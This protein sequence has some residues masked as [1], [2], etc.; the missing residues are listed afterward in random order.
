M[1]E[2]VQGTAVLR[3][4]LAI[5][6]HKKSSGKPCSFQ[7]LSV[8]LKIFFIFYFSII[9]SP[10]IRTI[11]FNG[12]YAARLFK[13]YFPNVDPE[14]TRIILPSTS[15]AHAVPL[16]KKLRAWQAVKDFLK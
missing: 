6:S 10:Q 15:P 9:Y 5:Q 7:N 14:I 4:F 2:P 8:W 3:K 11:A 13:R 1:P 16:E 12:Q